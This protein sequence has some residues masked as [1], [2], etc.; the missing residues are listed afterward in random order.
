MIA[1]DMIEVQI[2]ISFHLQHSNIVVR[3]YNQ[4]VDVSI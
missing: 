3:T 4:N 2:L 1:V